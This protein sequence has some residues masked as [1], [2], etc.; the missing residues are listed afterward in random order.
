MGWGKEKLVEAIIQVVGGGQ[1]SRESDLMTRKRHQMAMEKVV[2]R[3]QS[4]V[5]GVEAEMP[6]EFIALDLWDAWSA[7]GEITGETALPEEVINSIFE[8]FCIGK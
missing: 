3:L 7:L 8:E 2:D 1:I 4:A 6:L 5:K